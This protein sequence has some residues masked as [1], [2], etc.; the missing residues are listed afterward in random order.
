MKI[1]MVLLLAISLSMEISTFKTNGKEYLKLDNA[2]ITLND[3]TRTALNNVINDF[4]TVSNGNIGTSDFIAYL[5]PIEINNRLDY[6]N[7]YSLFSKQQLFYLGLKTSN[8]M[9]ILDK[10]EVKR[11][12]ETLN[13][14]PNYWI[15]SLI[16]IIGIVAIGSML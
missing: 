4:T 10:A 3:F 5:E 11:L 9:I 12:N 7:A 8:Q 14:K 1:L 16:G 13:A 2:K 6:I 15:P